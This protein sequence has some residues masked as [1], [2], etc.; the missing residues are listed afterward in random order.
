[1]TLFLAYAR[2][3]GRIAWLIVQVQTL[4]AKVAHY[5]TLMELFSQNLAT[6]STNVATITA[7]NVQLTEE[8]A[9]LAAL[10]THT[11]EDE[12]TLQTLVDQT[13]ATVAG[14]P[15]AE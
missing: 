15:V 6:L 14:F 13:N 8:N 2:L 12:Q 7:H 10:P 1:M 5:E 11:P 9:R 4:K 3:Q